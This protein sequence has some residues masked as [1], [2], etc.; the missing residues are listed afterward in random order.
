M[1]NAIQEYI[2]YLHN[3]RKT[4]FNTEISYRRDL[5]KAADFFAGQGITDI[6]RVTETNLNSYL[7][8]LERAGMSP[9]TVSRNIASLRSFF[10]YLLRKQVIAEDPSE[11]LRPPKVEKKAP[12]ILT[13]EEIR[14][15]LKQ[16]NEHTNKGV[17]DRAML[18]MLCATGI[19][20]SELVHCRVQDVNL[21]LG[22]VTCAENGRERMIPLNPET[23][24]ILAVYMESARE[25]LLKGNESEYLFSNCSGTRMTRQGFWKIL[26]GY[27][28][29]AGIEK[30][31]TPHTLR[32][33]FAMHMLQNGMDIRSVQKMMGHAD[34]STTQ[35]YVSMAVS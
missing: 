8:F 27:A 23:R 17:R 16:P 24:Q 14:L 10:Q 25:P 4:S 28:A 11:R 33:S 20:V 32:H 9:A 18:Q 6:T 13:A 7:L 15:L 5:D 22:Y 29:D 35:M 19:R 12:E 2:D 26:K 34:I 31:I 21:D 30:D 1:V 3:V